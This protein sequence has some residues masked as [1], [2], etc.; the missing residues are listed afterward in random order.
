[1]VVVDSSVLIPLSKIGRLELIKRN[2]DEI[3]TTEDDFKEVVVEGKGKKGT[4]NIKESFENWISVKKVD[5]DKA[6][7]IA[8]MEGIATADASLLLLVEKVQNGPILL[9][10]D[11]ALIL[12]AKS[13]N[14]EYYWLTTLILKSVRDGLISDVKGKEL[15]DDLVDVG[16]NLDTRVYSKI[17]KKSMKFDKV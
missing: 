2:F 16:M 4:S 14:I 8:E 12:V 5:T 9:T 10:N 3:I 15:L 1:M 11:R 17:I 6:K 7:D 13:R